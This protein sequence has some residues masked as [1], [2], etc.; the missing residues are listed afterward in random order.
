MFLYASV[1]IMTTNKIQNRICKEL[2]F[3]VN[4]TYKY[5]ERGINFIIIKL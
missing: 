1:E 5:D 3:C 4:D 2:K